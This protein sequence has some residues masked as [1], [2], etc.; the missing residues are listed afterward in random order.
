MPRAASTVRKPHTLTPERFFQLSPAQVSL[1]FSPACGME[2]K[3]QASL[4]VDM[5]QARTSPAGPCGGFSCVVPPVMTRFLYTIGGALKPLRPGIPRMISGVFRLRTP[6]SPKALFG[7]P[8]LAST[9]YN[10]PSPEP[11][12]T[13]G[14]VLESPAQY[15][16]PRVETELEG[17]RNA[18]SSFPV[19][20]S[21]ATTRP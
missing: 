21:S 17:R 9:E 20:G 11:N 4:P 14:G 7:L 13:C 3:V 10:L 8:V 18:Q 12:T 6:L 15:S 16:M 19:V 1:Y 5:S 2:W